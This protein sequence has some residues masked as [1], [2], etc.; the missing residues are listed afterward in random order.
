MYS[1]TATSYGFTL[2]NGLKNNA[3]CSN[4]A[5]TKKCLQ[6]QQNQQK[7]A[8]KSQTITSSYATN[9]QSA[10]ALFSSLPCNSA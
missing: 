7:L 5:T 1:I 4:I 6:N 8:S 9:R 2:K 3:I 10:A